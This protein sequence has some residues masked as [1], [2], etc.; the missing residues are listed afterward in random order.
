MRL[1]IEAANQQPYVNYSGRGRGHGRGH[2]YDG[3]GC[4]FSRVFGRGRGRG[5][6]RPLQRPRGGRYCHTH[7]SCAHN[8]ADYQTPSVT[9]K[10]AASFT[11]MMGGSTKNC[12]WRCGTTDKNNNKKQ[13][14]LSVIV[15]KPLSNSQKPW[16]LLKNETI[17][18][19]IRNI[20]PQN[21]P[22]HPLIKSPPI[23]KII[24]SD[25]NITPEE[26]LCTYYI[27]EYDKA[28]T[29]PLPPNHTLHW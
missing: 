10:P 9:H 26:L 5:E 4:S 28:S 20:P 19:P 14:F 3:R 16:N 21:I 11:D 22:P 29:T 1:Y 2:G 18:W 17:S 8:G 24:H 15:N 27:K 23:N 25:S 6:E 13:L 7:G 12:E